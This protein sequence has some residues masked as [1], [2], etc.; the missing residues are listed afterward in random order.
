MWLLWPCGVGHVERSIKRFL[1]LGFLDDYGPRDLIV[2]ALLPAVERRPHEAEVE[3]KGGHEIAEQADDWAH[4]RGGPAG[5]CVDDLDTH[6]ELAGRGA[7]VAPET[8][9]ERAHQ[10][11]DHE[12]A[13]AAHRV[14]GE[15]VRAEAHHDDRHR[16]HDDDQPVDEERHRALPEARV[17]EPRVGTLAGSWIDALSR[18]RCGAVPEARLDALRRA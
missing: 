18:R 8:D 7:A 3:R 9:D 2:P 10:G 5:G 16:D 1:S 12:I 4:G 11:G 17:V 13:R 15:I 6:R 14:E